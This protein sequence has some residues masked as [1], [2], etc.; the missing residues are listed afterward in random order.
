MREESK[1]FIQKTWKCQTR[2]LCFNLVRLKISKA[3][4][5]YVT[6]I[7]SLGLVKPSTDPIL[8]PF[9]SKSLQSLATCW[10]TT[11]E[12]DLSLFSHNL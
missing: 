12:G 7:A 1:D 11:L 10:K 5:A 3:R 4:M 8:Q 2:V 6:E 9:T